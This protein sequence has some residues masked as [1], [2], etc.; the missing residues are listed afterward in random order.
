M[1]E[2]AIHCYQQA[3][4]AAL[5]AGDLS[6]WANLRG[7]MSRIAADQG[8]LKRAADLADH[9]LRRG[10]TRI[11]PAVRCW[12]HAVGAHHHAGLDGAR[13]ASAA[14]DEAWRLLGHCDDGEIPP[15]IGYISPMEIGKWAGHTFVR[16]ATKRPQRRNQ[17]PRR[18]PG[19]LAKRSTPR[20]R[21]GH[22]RQ[23]PHLPRQR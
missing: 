21:R 5:E 20:L 12:L 8:H 1:A 23:R 19:R 11:H 7:Q 18:G 10:G 13:N 6:S 2:A 22:H 4:E 9:A 17:S 3:A 16:L 14:L 15:Y